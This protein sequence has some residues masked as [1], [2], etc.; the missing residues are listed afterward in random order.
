MPPLSF[1]CNFFDM[2]SPEIGS[3]FGPDTSVDVSRPPK[4]PPPVR[5]SGGDYPDLVAALGVLGD[6]F[7]IS[8]REDGSVVHDSGHFD[9]RDH[10]FD[11][12]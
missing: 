2:A 1:I 9:L 7:Q 3:E 8:L 5:S 12:C 11:D 10:E 4:S 6:R